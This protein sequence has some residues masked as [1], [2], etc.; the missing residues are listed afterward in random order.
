MDIKTLKPLIEKY[1]AKYGLRPEIVYGV[2]KKESSFNPFAARF[3]TAYRY[4]YKAQDLKPDDCS[5][6]TEVALQKTSFG[7]MQ[8]MGGVL[9]EHGYQGWLTAIIADVE[10][11]LNY[12]CKH[13]KSKIDK[14][15]ELRGISAYNAGSP[16]A[17]NA[18]YVSRVMAYSREWPNA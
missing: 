4:I 18:E 17:N 8:C 7:L 12:G 2:I 3:E 11:Q 5:L 1:A 9:R 15:G 14:Y 16:T 6:T 13:L 10:A